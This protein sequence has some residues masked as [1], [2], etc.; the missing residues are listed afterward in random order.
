MIPPGSMISPAFFDSCAFDGGDEDEQH[1]S[2][3]VR[4]LLDEH[5]GEIVILHSVEKEIHYKKTPR[6]VKD[7][8]ATYLHSLQVALTTEEA[9][10]LRDIER[11]IVGDGSL[12]NRRADCRHVFEAQK[13]GRYFA[14]TDNDILKRSAALKK[15]LSTL[16]VVRPTEFVDIVRRHV[17]T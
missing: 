1:A 11:I 9:S 2:Q 17:E 6:W 15:R 14:T 4:R 5:G 3:E 13:Y 8:A 16:F 10:V 12:E 7:C